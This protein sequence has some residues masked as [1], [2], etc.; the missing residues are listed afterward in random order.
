[1]EGEHSQGAD[2]ILRWLLGGSGTG[3]ASRVRRG[4]WDRLPSGMRRLRPA[5]R[6]R[7][8]R[9][10][11]GRDWRLVFGRG[12]WDRLPSGMRRLRPAERVRP[13]RTAVGRDWRLVFGRGCW[14]RLPSGLRRLRP[15]ERGRFSGMAGRTGS[16][17]LM[18]LPC[19]MFPL[20]MGYLAW[21]FYFVCG[22]WSLE[23]E[24]A[25]RLWMLLRVRT[26]DV[27]FIAC[28]PTLS[29]TSLLKIHCVLA[30]PSEGWPLD[31]SLH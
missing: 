9:T 22:Y 10:A 30:A 27:D 2:P 17:R 28:W 11:V 29:A 25:K 15:A 3:L 26:R 14:D 16:E 31:G 20:G 24:P 1:M 5:E 13:S 7:P 21:L 6:V 12:C 19:R 4:C 8:S 23:R 18:C